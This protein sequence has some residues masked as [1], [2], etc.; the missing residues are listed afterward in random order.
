MLQSLTNSILEKVPQ[1]YVLQRVAEISMGKT[2]R[3]VQITPRV[4]ESGSE[5]VDTTIQQ[6]DVIN[7]N[8]NEMPTQRLA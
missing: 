1:V 7:L 3:I 8:I 4:L 5:Y 2:V 6:F